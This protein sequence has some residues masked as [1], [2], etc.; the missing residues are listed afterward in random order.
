MVLVIYS[1]VGGEDPISMEDRSQHVTAT[2]VTG[3]PSGVEPTAVR[4]RVDGRSYRSSPRLAGPQ[5]SGDR[6]VLAYDPEAPARTWQP[7]TDEELPDT[8]APAAD[9][10]LFLGLVLMAVGAVVAR[11]ATRRSWSAGRPAPWSGLRFDGR[12]GGPQPLR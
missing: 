11:P 12:G 5:R 3:H 9:L 7:G 4:Y 1:M 8:A 10:A 2:V 6:V